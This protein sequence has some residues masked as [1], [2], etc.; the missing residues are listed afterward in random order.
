MKNKITKANAAVAKSFILDFL[1]SNET[2]NVSE[3]LEAARSRYPDMTRSIFS[4]ALLQLRRNGQ[5]VS[6]ERGV[7]SIS[8]SYYIGRNERFPHCSVGKTKPYK[9]QGG[10]GLRY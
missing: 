10:L 2:A 9:F 3:M 4:G 5:I 1:E 6:L 8:E 7:Y